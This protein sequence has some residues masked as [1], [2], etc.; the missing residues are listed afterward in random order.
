MM[1]TLFRLFTDVW[2]LM[3]ICGVC[4]LTEAR[5]E[6]FCGRGEELLKK[7]RACGE[8]VEILYRDIFRAVQAFYQRKGKQ[9]DGEKGQ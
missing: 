7:Y 6:R 1:W 2:E 5:W 4:R 8:D 3:K 9:D